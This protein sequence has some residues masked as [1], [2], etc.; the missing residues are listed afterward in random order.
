MALEKTCEICGSLFS[1]RPYRAATARFCSGHCRGVFVGTLPHIKNPGHRPW[2][3]GNK[4]A[5]GHRNATTF[6]P[7]DRPWNADMKGIHLSPESEFKPGRQVIRLPI[8][9]VRTRQR[10]RDNRPRAYIKVAEPN[11]WRL[12]AQMVWEAHHGPMKRG[13]VI[14]HHDRDTLNDDIA[15]L[16]CMTKAEHITEHQQELREARW[17][18]RPIASL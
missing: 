11:S 10:K 14:H 5:A 6:K 2:L 9:T 3:I 18:L 8:G 4:F 7:G 13:M 15:N 1:V 17:P 12:R 16:R